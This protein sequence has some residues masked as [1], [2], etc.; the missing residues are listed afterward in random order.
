MHATEKLF[1]KSSIE[2][3]VLSTLPTLE[4]QVKTVLDT[5]IKT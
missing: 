2:Q 3:A 5:Y 4:G 1:A